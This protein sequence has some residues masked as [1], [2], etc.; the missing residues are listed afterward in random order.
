[1]ERFSKSDIPPD[2]P[3]TAGREPEVK[4]HVLSEAVFCPRAAILAHESGEDS[5]DEEPSLGPRLDGFWDYD[6]HRFVEELHSAWGKVR[7]WLTLAAPATLVVIVAWRLVSPAVGAAVS[8][9][10]FIIV[11]RLW[12]LLVRILCLVREQAV[13]AAAAPVT[14]DLASDQVREVNW[15][16]LRKAG[17]DC[18]KPI[19]P[20]HDPGERLAGKPWRV[21]SKDT[22]RR[23]PV[24]RKHRGKRDWGAQHVVRA[25]AY[26]QL[27]KTCELGDA[28]FAVL[29]FAGSYDCVLLPNTPAARFQFE[30][31]L[32]DT[33]EL[34]RECKEGKSYPAEPTDTRC[35]GCPWGKPRRYMVGKSDTILNG[36]AIAA[37]RVKA[38]VP[39]GNGVTVKY[40]HSSCG[41]RFGGWVPPHDDAVALEIAERR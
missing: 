31:A 21:L 9:P 35:S 39:R 5:G 40:F 13:F 36:E 7:F 14:L 27:V 25:A 20:Y 41:D 10:L 15:W 8:L 23:I 33:R 12:D 26:C 4:V 3:P 2:R 32:E 1:M 16:S 37:R 6:E 24:I 11:A 17:F 38:V 29:L 19:D 18:R 28:P 34:L 22:T 30:K